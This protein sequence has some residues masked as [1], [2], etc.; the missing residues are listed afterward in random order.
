MN[1]KTTLAFILLC[2]SFAT[3]GQDAIVPPELM[4]WIIEVQKANPA[5]AI[6]DFELESQSDANYEK[7]PE[8]A[9]GLYPVLKKWNYS[10]DRYA[11]YDLWAELELEKD[12]RYA[13]GRD[14]DSALGI[15]DRNDNIF[16]R[17]SFGSSKEI[18]GLYWLKD[19]ILIAAGISITFANSDIA[20]VDLII[21]EYNLQKDKVIIKEYKYKNA[22]DNVTRLRLQLEWWDQRPDYFSQ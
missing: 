3:F 9:T 14:I 4:W 5:I 20:M 13:V 17:D 11:Y 1:K 2:S 18:N 12:G 6:P 7:K 16:F 10:G 19:S 15:I 8:K 22:F 21:R